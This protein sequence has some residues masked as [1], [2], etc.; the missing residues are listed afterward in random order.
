MVDQLRQ[1]SVNNRRFGDLRLHRH[2]SSTLMME[3]E[4]VSETLVIGSTLTGLIARQDFRA[5]ICH[6]SFKSRTYMKKKIS[7]SF[8]LN[9]VTEERTAAT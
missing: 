7:K 3:A 8:H 9:V 1:Y 4:E 2:R 6:G 5:F